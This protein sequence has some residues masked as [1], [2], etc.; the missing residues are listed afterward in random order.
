MEEWPRNPIRKDVWERLEERDLIKLTHESAR[1]MLNSIRAG[2]VS[3]TAET[4][5]YY[6]E[7]KKWS[8]D[9]G[10]IRQIVNSINDKDLK[11]RDKFLA[12]SKRFEQWYH[13]SGLTLDELADELELSHTSIS[14][15][16]IH[17]KKTGKPK[18]N[19]RIYKHY[20]AAYSLIFGVSPYYL[21][22]VTDD[23][24]Q[25]ADPRKCKSVT[26]KSDLDKIFEAFDAQLPPIGVHVAVGT[27][28]FAI[29]DY[30]RTYMYMD[31]SYI[32]ENFVLPIIACFCNAGRNIRSKMK[33]AIMTAPKISE[34]MNLDD[35]KV[36]P[37]AAAVRDEYVNSTAI[38]NI[39]TAL[40]SLSFKDFE[41][42]QLVGVLMR[43]D[44]QFKK[45]VYEFLCNGGFFDD[46]KAYFKRWKCSKIFVS[47]RSN[48]E[49]MVLEKARMEN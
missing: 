21:L 38:N 25:Y 14:N 22:G 34:R 17:S 2:E 45:A 11:K 20:L 32:N 37:Y 47:N 9:T 23:P 41:S 6:E 28:S 39:H 49:M 8:N 30:I 5:K 12:F 36:D 27:R 3:A 18:P 42:L 15:S 31:P 29:I 24:H 16:Y 13:K 7:L 40:T 10:S 48:P 1:A 46:P 19:S 43:Q 4:I 44:D 33:K 26:E 35:W